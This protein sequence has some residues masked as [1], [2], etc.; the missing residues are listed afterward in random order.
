MGATPEASERLVPRCPV[1]DQPGLLE[2]CDPRGVALCPRCG[3]L[4]RW[5]QGR[6][7]SLYG[8]ADGIA[9]AT[10]FFED[11][12]ADSFDIVELVME[13]EETFAVRVPDEE[14]AQIKT[15]EDAIRCIQR[16]TVRHQT[17]NSELE[18]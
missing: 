17:V 13:L 7:A 11:L 3:H 18:A 12:G 14:A 1:C 4:L 8:A 5:F 2:L 9:L 16:H 10:S 15:L 6:L